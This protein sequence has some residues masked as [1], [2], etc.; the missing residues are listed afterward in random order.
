MTLLKNIQLLTAAFWIATIFLSKAFADEVFWCKDSEGIKRLRNYQC[1][2]NENEINRQTSSINVK[3]PKSKSAPSQNIPPSFG[4]TIR[5]QQQLQYDRA[6]RADILEKAQQVVKTSDNGAAMAAVILRGMSGTIGH[7]ELMSPRE[8]FEYAQI[9][10]DDMLKV[11]KQAAAMSSSN[12]TLLF[13]AALHGLD[14]TSP[15]MSPSAKPPR[16]AINAQTGEIYHGANEGIINP[17]NG[18]FYPDVGGGYIN[19]ATGQFIPKQ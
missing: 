3:P 12:G 13:E 10:R 16:S 14:T 8:Q 9:S 17:R 4:T 5:V 15:V 2:S 18:Q 7:N 1:G 11:A 19:P 6:S